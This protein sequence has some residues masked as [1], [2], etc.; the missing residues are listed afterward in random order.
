MASALKEL[1][2]AGVPPEDDTVAQLRFGQKQHTAFRHF[3][4]CMHNFGPLDRILWQLLAPSLT[5]ARNRKSLGLPLVEAAETEKVEAKQSINGMRGDEGNADYAQE[6]A[7]VDAGAI[8]GVG[9]EQ[10]EKKEGD[11]GQ[12]AVGGEGEDDDLPDL[13]VYGESESAPSRGKKGRR[14][15]KKGK[16]RGKGAPK[17]EESVLL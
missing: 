6:G 4:L 17:G 11:G 15:V 2:D 16:K 1:R 8:K 3:V 7:R 14:K 12:G 10:R 13:E 5:V 9:A